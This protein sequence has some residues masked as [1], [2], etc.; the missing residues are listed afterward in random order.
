M[1][2]F[3]CLRKMYDR[4]QARA[5]GFQIHR[6]A[7]AIADSIELEEDHVIFR[8]DTRAHEIQRGGVHI[9]VFPREDLRFRLCLDV[10]FIDAVRVQE[11]TILFALS[12]VEH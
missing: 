8:S 2:V 5:L 4:D 12:C 3:I 7:S 6:A 1:W 11:E 10:E 9:G